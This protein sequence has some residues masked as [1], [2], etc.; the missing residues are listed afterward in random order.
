MKAELGAQF[1]IAGLV[2]S[3]DR[4]GAL[5]HFDPDRGFALVARGLMGPTDLIDPTIWVKEKIAL[6]LG[7]PGDPEDS[8]LRRVI[9][10]LRALHGELMTRPEKDRPWVSV[11]VLILQGEDAVAV[12]AGDCPCFRFRSGLLSRLGRVEPDAGPHAPR[13]ALGSEPQ[14]RIEIVPLR[15]PPGDL[16]VLSTR[17]LR[18]G[19]LAVLARDLSVASDGAQLLRSGAEG[20]SDRG[21][22]AIRV[23]VASESDDLAA[24]ADSIRTPTRPP[25][26]EESAPVAIERAERTEAIASALEVESLG[27][28]GDDA[29]QV[30]DSSLLDDAI[31][32]EDEPATQDLGDTGGFDDAELPAA[33]PDEIPMGEPAFPRAG[34]RVVSRP[35]DHAQ[36]ITMPIRPDDLAGPDDLVGVEETHATSAV[37]AAPEEVETAAY[38]DEAGAPAYHEAVPAQARASGWPE[39]EEL[40]TEVGRPAARPKRLASIGEERPWYEPFALWAGGALALVA[41]A[42]LIRSLAPG[43]LGSSKGKSAA[44]HAVVGATGLADIFSEPPGATVRV[45]GVALDGKTPLVGVSLDA[46]L[47]RVELDWG[48]WGVWRDTLE[49]T[50]GTRLTIHPAIQGTATFRS[51]DNARPLDVYLDGVYA[52]STPLSLNDV[53]VGRHLVRFGGPGLTTSAQEIEVL[54]DTPVELVGNAGPV[55]ATG[56]LTVRTAVL[57]D[58]GFESG[59]GDPYWVDGVARG[60]TPATMDLKPGTH[61]VRVVRRGFPAQITV[62]DVKSGTEQFVTAEFGADSAEPLHFDPPDFISIANPTPL[63][64][65]LPESEWDPAMALWIY[66]ATPAGTFQAKRMTR[67]EEGTRTF[68]ALLPTEVLRGG[69]REVK[70]YFKATGVGGREIYSEIYTVP[71]KE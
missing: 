2:R 14:V 30:L 13:G 11:L 54:R 15:P 23:L 20:S 42:L 60:V 66:A 24:I 17:A 44:P 45:D 37:P 33:F 16:Y 3:P 64:I 59:K 27:P 53:V 10:A 69:A 12:S 71:V 47:H 4:E 63:T 8:P 9:G 36:E 57:N 56:K 55:P 32:E 50:S 46:G 67:L 48:P 51:S 21:R 19:E 29:V 35:S 25:A 28:P 26:A 22:V 41:L 52:G 49:V 31:V 7:A 58:T 38:R 62:L 18:D 5:A 70:F 68:A 39:A 65:A 43:I 6:A 61:S 1:R 40:E 34:A